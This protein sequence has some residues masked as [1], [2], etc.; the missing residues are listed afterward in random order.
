MLPHQR[1][2]SLVEALDDCWSPTRW[3]KFGISFFADLLHQGWGSVFLWKVHS[4][5]VRARGAHD[6]GSTGK[7]CE[8]DH[9]TDSRRYICAAKSGM[10]LIH[11]WIFN[12]KQVVDDWA[13][14]LIPL[15]D[16]ETARALDFRAPDAC[17]QYVATRLALRN[18]LPMYL[19][20]ALGE[21]AYVADALGKL[22]LAARLDESDIDFSISHSGSVAGLAFVR[23]ASVGIDLEK[24]DRGAS[25]FEVL[26]IAFNDLERR[27]AELSTEQFE[28]SLLFAWTVKEAVCK[29]AGC[30][31]PD[32][33]R[34]IDTSGASIRIQR[35]CASSGE[36]EAFGRSWWVARLEQR[37]S[38]TGAVAALARKGP[39]VVKQFRFPEDLAAACL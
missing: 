22:R 9:A 21:D 5:P 30:G 31:L 26:D 15:T 4:G 6:P 28:E 7:P 37:G 12:V 14:G 8:I 2:A 16:A 17:R 3:E 35:S 29:A 32:D 1:E 10:N 34:E 38:Y 23:G 18:I 19:G 13:P 33:P 36:V 25:M 24:V 27:A 20:N 39:Y 11:T